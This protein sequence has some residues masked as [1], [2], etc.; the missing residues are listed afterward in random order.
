MMMHE[1]MAPLQL[2]RIRRHPDVREEHLVDLLDE[3]DEEESV[4][5]LIEFLRQAPPPG[6]F[7]S[8]TTSISSLEDNKWAKIVK[9]RKK[10]KG[11]KKRRP[12][13]PDI[14]LP[15]SA[16]AATTI[17]GHRHISISIPFQYSH[18]GA[19][20]A[21]Q[22]PIFN[23][24]ADDFAR[25]IETRLRTWGPTRSMS[26]DKVVTVL[27][28]VKEEKESP[29]SPERATFQT[30]SPAVQKALTQGRQ[31]S[32]RSRPSC[33]CPAGLYCPRP[34]CQRYSGSHT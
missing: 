11:G 24:V 32:P 16:V 31:N 30:T 19:I 29:R 28:P 25:E 33:Q 10:R 22:Y 4:R 5:H 26:N 20:S 6:N 9:F 23:S 1:K 15:D 27:K 3:R 2:T 14:R 13:P 34:S 12:S 21:S 18:L 7:M 17:G 8:D